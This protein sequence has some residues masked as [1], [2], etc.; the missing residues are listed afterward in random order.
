MKAF[1][2]ASLLASAAIPVSSFTPASFGVKRGQ[3]TTLFE[4]K[5]VFIDGEAGTTGLQVRQR[6]E[7]RDDL[8]IISPPDDL[9]KDADT[10]KKFINMADAV[11]L[12]LPDDASIE[13][14]SFVDAD[15]DNTVLIDASTA[16]RIADDWEYGFPGMRFCIF[17]DG[18]SLF[19]E[20]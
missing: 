8:E 16:Y 18:A 19:F 4:K 12:C 5:K 13:A 2:F 3:K 7:G 6:L 15:N 20:R 17:S 11:I 9:R 14:T 10:R 1:G